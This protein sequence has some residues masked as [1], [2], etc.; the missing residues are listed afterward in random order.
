MK[1]TKRRTLIASLIGNILEH[2]DKA[3]YVLIA[4]FIAFL[5]YPKFHPI[6]ALILVYLPVSFI[7]RPIGALF[8]GYFGDKYGYKKALQ[9]SIVGM[10]LMILFIGLIPTYASIGITSAFILHFLRGMICFFAAGEGTAAALVLINQAPKKYKD[11]FSSI[12]EMSS[13]IGVMIA[14]GFITFLLFQ[15]KI[16]SCWRSLFIF[17]GVLGLAGFLFRKN[18]FDL[19]KPKAKIS[20]ISLKKNWPAF[21]SI[22][23]VTGFTYANYIIMS[24]L[25][26]GYL[27]LVSSLKNTHIMS[28]Q[29]W[30]IFFDFLM[31]PVFGYLSKRYSKE[32]IITIALMLA[33]VFAIPVFSLLNQPTFSNLLLLRIILVTWGI[34]IAAPYEYWMIDLI[35][36]KERFRIIALG[37]AIG[38]QWIGAPAISVS[39]WMFQKTKWVAIPSLYIMITGVGALSALFFLYRRHFKGSFAAKPNNAS[40]S[41]Q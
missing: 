26:N 8:F 40:Y 41:S 30:L 2:Y 24:S 36:P 20:S 33:V 12:Y 31:L 34:A 28:I 39:L 4:P 35:A 18:V 10:S 32:K 1:N 19:E 16:I 11:I 21:L 37:K 13:M 14:S 25:M 27:P 6:T 5:F 38:A 9:L 17:S 3:L 22:I 7:F 15:D 29:T 23:F